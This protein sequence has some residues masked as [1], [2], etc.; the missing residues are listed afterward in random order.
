MIHRAEHKSNFSILS[1]ETIRNANLSLEARGLLHY[2]LSFPDDW[3][4]SMKKVSEDQNV[5]TK[6][7]RRIV[8]ELV[9][10]GYVF[11][12]K[13]RN[14]FGQYKFD[15]EVNE[16]PS[17]SEES[18]KDKI[19]K[20]AKSAVKTEKSETSEEKTSYPTGNPTKINNIN[21]KK[22][23]IKEKEN[24]DYEKLLNEFG[25]GGKVRKAMMDY[26]QMRNSSNR[27]LYAKGVEYIITRLKSLSEDVSIQVEMLEN[28]IMGGWRSVWLPKKSR[29]SQVGNLPDF[30][31]NEYDFDKLEEML[32]V[33]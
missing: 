26:I 28:A 10:A 33:N 24:I 25:L 30:E 23:N 7:L 32:V 19:R 21:I 6:V 3:K 1:N 11:M 16:R 31:Q 5:S 15:Y 14:A 4:F 18:W 13:K 20:I 12:E 9:E 29:K 8:N 17:N 2:M 27:P 22:K